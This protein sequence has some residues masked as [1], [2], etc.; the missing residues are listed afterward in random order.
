MLSILLLLANNNYT[1]AADISFETGISVPVFPGAKDLWLGPQEVDIN[2]Y[3][4]KM[5]CFSVNNTIEKILDFYQRELPN[6]GWQ[7]GTVWEGLNIM[8]FTKED[9]F[10]YVA[11][12]DTIRGYDLSVTKFV[13][14][15][16]KRELHLCV[17]ATFVGGP[18]FKET[19]G[20]DLAFIPRYPGA[21]RVASIIRQDKEA[22]FIYMVRED[23]IKIADFYRKNLP[24]YGWRISKR[25]SV[26]RSCIQRSFSATAL[27]FNRGSE[28][29]LSIHISYCAE[30]RANVVLISYNYAFNYAVWPLGM[31]QT[32]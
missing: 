19:P 7:L 21:V 31:N 10:L 4:T 3:S 27:L 8:Y 14:V 18:N 24:N 26:P 5:L 28:D 15:L 16:S 6:Y 12:S 23:A 32:W 9:R 1:C 17:A 2:G 11:A 20:R 22:F 29:T 30:S 13:L 25:L